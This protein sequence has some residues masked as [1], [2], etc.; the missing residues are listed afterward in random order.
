MPW[1]KGNGRDLGVDD[2]GND[3]LSLVAATPHHAIG[4][5]DLSGVRGQ[6][7]PNSAPIQDNPMSRVSIKTKAEL[8]PLLRHG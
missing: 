7:R 3:G 8:Q 1:R 4:D 5:I 2:I 6:H